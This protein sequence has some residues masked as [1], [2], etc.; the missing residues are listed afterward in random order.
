MEKEIKKK[1]K[2]GQSGS[3]GLGE[4]ESRFSNESNKNL[5]IKKK[6]TV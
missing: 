5:Q 2:T 4:G 6:K 3:Q 1:N